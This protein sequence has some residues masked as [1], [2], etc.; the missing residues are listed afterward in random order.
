MALEDELARASPTRDTVLT[1]GVFDGV[2]LG[3][4]HLIEQVKAHARRLDCLSAAVT[5]TRHPLTVITPET[6]IAY[7]TSLE[8]RLELM[9]S[10]GLELLVPLTFTSEVRNLTPR[11]FV[12]LLREKLR[13]RGIVIGP[14]FSLG[15]DRQGNAA[16][17]SSLGQE[18]GYEVASVEPVTRGGV[19]VSSTAVREVLARGEVEEVSKLLGRPF[20]ITG[21]V[22]PGAG[23]GKALGFP[24]ANL[25][26]PSDQALP[27]DGIY[28]GRVYLGQR[29][30]K[31]A[32]NIGFRPTFEQEDRAVEAFLLDFEGDL[33]G[34]RLKLELLHRLRKEEKFASEEELKAQIARDVEMARKLLSSQGP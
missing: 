22:V 25:D 32:V 5:F 31:A 4:Q 23:R 34:E 7:L 14:D 10:H 19:V 17:L 3:H 26:Y 20:S 2:H 18:L 24:T 1:V 6:S 21:K 11:Q 12:S 33:Y 27:A 28:V 8:Q 15:R 13:M 29:V 16:V 9:R 30:L